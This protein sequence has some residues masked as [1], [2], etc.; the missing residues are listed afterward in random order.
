MNQLHP[1]VALSVFAAEHKLRMAEAERARQAE[2][3]VRAYAEANPPQAHRRQSGLGVLGSAIAAVTGWIA[4]SVDPD[5]R[6]FR[7]PARRGR[8]LAS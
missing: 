1:D 6:T 5:R 8:S 4:S 2:E 3:A 7:P